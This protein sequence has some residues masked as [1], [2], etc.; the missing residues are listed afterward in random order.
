MDRHLSQSAWVSASFWASNGD[1][2]AADKT[3]RP[4][5]VR[6]RIECMES[7]LVIGMVRTVLSLRMAPVG[8]YSASRR[9][10]KCWSAV[11]GG[12]GEADGYAHDIAP[13]VPDSGTRALPGDDSGNASRPGLARRDH[14]S[15]GNCHGRRRGIARPQQRHA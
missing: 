2:K 10:A 7:V 5:S 15:C 12:P 6:K 4:P 1:A 11:D 14:S 3:S 9:D 13:Y 8:R